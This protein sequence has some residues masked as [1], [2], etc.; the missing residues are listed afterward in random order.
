MYI[1]IYPGFERNPVKNKKVM[2]VWDFSY[3]GP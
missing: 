3:M 2:E 1:N